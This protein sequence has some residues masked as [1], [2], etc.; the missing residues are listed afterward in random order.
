MVSFDAGRKERGSKM[1]MKVKK[2][3]C[4]ALLVAMIGSPMIQGTMENELN[5]HPRHPMIIIPF[6]LFEDED[7]EG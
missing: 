5:G 1:L 4:T 7:G 6:D 3:L 2:L